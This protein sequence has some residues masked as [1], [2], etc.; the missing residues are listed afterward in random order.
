MNKFI[1]VSLISILMVGCSSPYTS[2]EAQEKCAKQS[3]STFTNLGYKTE[4]GA[5]YENHFNIRLGKCFVE[6]S[7]VNTTEDSVFI[8]KTLFD[9]YE[10][11][12]YATLDRFRGKTNSDICMILEKSC[13]SET[14]YEDF[15][16]IY[17]ED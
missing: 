8:Q 5:S 15:V 3:F 17:L 6:I 7:N 2:L 16:K 1:L 11:K 10:S 12:V 4:E 13:S 9:A 14:E